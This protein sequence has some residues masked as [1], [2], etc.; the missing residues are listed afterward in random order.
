[1]PVEESSIK[2]FFAG[3]EK[4]GCSTPDSDVPLADLFFVI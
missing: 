2:L 3:C 4:K 1:M